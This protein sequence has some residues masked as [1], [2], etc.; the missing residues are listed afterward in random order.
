MEWEIN[1]ELSMLRCVIFPK[2]ILK[3]IFFT[4][5]VKTGHLRAH[6]FWQVPQSYALK[7]TFSGRS[8]WSIY[9]RS[10]YTADTFCN[11]KLRTTFE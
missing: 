2:L 6:L 8:G 11:E 5:R 3:N 1:A 7:S 9:V 10:F 4:A